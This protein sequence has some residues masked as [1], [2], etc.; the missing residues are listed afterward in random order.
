MDFG[1]SLFNETTNK[2]FIQQVKKDLEADS[3]SADRLKSP[4]FITD[5]S[6]SKRKPEKVAYEFEDFKHALKEIADA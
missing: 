5:S 3:P 4:K 2:L 6:M 1:F